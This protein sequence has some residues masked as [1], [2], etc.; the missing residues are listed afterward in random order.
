MELIAKSRIITHRAKPQIIYPLIRLPKSEASIAGEHAYI[1][2]TECNGKPLYVISLDENF[3]GY[4]KVIQPPEQTSLEARVEALEKQ[5]A[6]MQRS[7]PEAVIECSGPAEIQNP[8]YA[9]GARFGISR[10]AQYRKSDGRNDNEKCKISS[11]PA[12]IRTPDLRR[13]KATS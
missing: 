3:D 12:E 9:S 8:D 7:M 6:L 1:F 11:G 13:V 2:K 4:L 5:L 10:C